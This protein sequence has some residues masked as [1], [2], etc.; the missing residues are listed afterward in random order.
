MSNE[1]NKSIEARE[2]T[3]KELEGVV[4][5]TDSMSGQ[6]ETESPMK[7]TVEQLAWK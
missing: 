3:E 5:G 2:M 4:G 1:P 7:R 6:G